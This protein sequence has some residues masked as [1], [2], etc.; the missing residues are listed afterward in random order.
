MKLFV[1]FIRII[2]LMTLVMMIVSLREENAKLKSQ[3][4][5]LRAEKGS[6]NAEY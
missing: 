4:I 1:L 5:E 6:I 3:I 2:I